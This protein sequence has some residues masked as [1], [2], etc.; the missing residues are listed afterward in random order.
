MLSKC[1]QLIRLKLLVK[2]RKLLVE[3]GIEAL[4]PFNV[5]VARDKLG[6]ARTHV[7]LASKLAPSVPLLIFLL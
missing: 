1:K 6:K 5:S 3:N 2:F 7:G 4:L